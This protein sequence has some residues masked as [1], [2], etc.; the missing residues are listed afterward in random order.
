MNKVHFWGGEVVLTDVGAKYRSVEASICKSISC[1]LF[2][3]FYFV[4][5]CNTENKA[6]FLQFVNSVTTQKNS[7]IYIITSVI[8]CLGIV[9]RGP[10][11]IAILC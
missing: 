2:A 6:E 10:G 8:C 11:G 4:I 3:C 5:P 7:P 1:V 9:V